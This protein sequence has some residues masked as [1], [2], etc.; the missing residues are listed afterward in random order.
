MASEIL[1]SKSV[2][3]NLP[4]SYTYAKMGLHFVLSFTIFFGNLLTV[5][6]VRQS[7][8][9]RRAPTNTLIVSLAIADG[10][11]GFSITPYT[12]TNKILDDE[13]VRRV[14]VC[15]VRA[16][17][18]ALLSVLLYTLLMIAIDRFL[19]IVYPL[20]YRRT[21]TIPRARVLL[22]FVWLC[23]FTVVITSTCYF[24][25]RVSIEKIRSGALHDLFPNAAYVWAIQSV[26]FV[27]L[28]G[29]LILYCCIYVSLR[30]RKPVGNGEHRPSKMTKVVTRMMSM[31]LGY[32]LL[33]FIPYFVLVPLYNINDSSTP[34]WYNIAFDISVIMFYSNSLVNP[35][36]YSWQNS[37]FREAYRKV[38]RCRGSSIS[39]TPDN[40]DNSSCTDRTIISQM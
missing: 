26:V 33:A 18:Y 19:A 7:T 24:G 35:L 8:K 15:V 40:N 29:N 32:L 34:T 17:N 21:V 22:V 38:L 39:T 5:V 2:V 10:L 11:L 27:P 13:Q 6:A 37:E 4:I 28:A 25:S 9:L 36:I 23:N 14:S 1:P 30:R 12:I 16:P 3:Q 20:S 31:V